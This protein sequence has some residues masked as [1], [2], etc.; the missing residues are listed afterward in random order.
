ME[1]IIKLRDLSTEFKVGKKYIK[2][3]KNVSLDVKKGQILSIVGESGCGK[4][5]T[6]NSMV[7]LLPKTANIT[8]G[9]SEFYKEDGTTIDI[10]KEKAYGKKMRTIR[11]K[12]IG[13]IFQDP[14][15]SLNPVYTVG[16]QIMENI[17]EHRKISK[18]EARE[19]G[20]EMLRKLGIPEPESRFDNYP[21][22]FSGGMKQ[23]DRKSVV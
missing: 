21:H 23:R 20:I 10:L 19:I 18:K 5:V 7:K 6:V 11:G 14:M 9:T 12:E 4:S 13:M 3:V 1:N 2:I 15:Q 16:D 22:Q 17:L 8:S